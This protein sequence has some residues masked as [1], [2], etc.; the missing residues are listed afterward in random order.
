MVSKNV[1]K[2]IQN[3]EKKKFREK[4]NLFKIEGEKMVDELLRSTFKIKYI[5]ASEK[6]Y[7]EHNN[8]IKNIKYLFISLSCYILFIAKRINVILSM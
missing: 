6:W 1:T 5:F 8:A 4:Y 2:L 3:L 7:S